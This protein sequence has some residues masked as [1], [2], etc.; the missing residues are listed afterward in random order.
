MPEVKASI[1]I[2]AP[3]EKV[4]AIVMDPERL[5]EWV[6]IHRKLGKIS[7][8]PLKRGSTLE[9]TL[10]IRGVNLKVSWT[11]DCLDDG[12]STEWEGKGPARSKAR[13]KYVLESDGDGG[14]RFDYENDFRAPFGPLGA[15]ASKALVGGVPEREA[16]RSLDALKQLAESAG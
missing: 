5:G 15:A 11:V 6:T 16:Q 13:T 7:D 9:Q 10:C 2:A 8:R 14:T 3:P 4:W 12:H 1:E